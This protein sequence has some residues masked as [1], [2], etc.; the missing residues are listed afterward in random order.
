[1]RSQLELVVHVEADQD[2]AVLLDV[3]VGDPADR[4]AGDADLV[5]DLQAGDV[6]ELRAVVRSC[7]RTACRRS[8]LPARP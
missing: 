5:A 4:D 2:R 1:V 7:R 8:R 3:D 6:G